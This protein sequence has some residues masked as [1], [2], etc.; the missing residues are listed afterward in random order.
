[1]PRFA[2]GSVCVRRRLLGVAPSFS[3]QIKNR[4]AS[5]LSSSSLLQP[6]TPAAVAQ[7]RVGTHALKIVEVEKHRRT[8]SGR[9][10]QIR[11]FAHRVWANRVA[12]VRSQ[13][14]AIRAFAGEHIEVV[15]PE[16]DHHFLQLPLAINSS[17]NSRSL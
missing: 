5:H 17:Q 9:F 12:I 16:I 6:P 10:Q 14:P 13:Q 3:H 2:F 11:E 15:G 7:L 8:F 4:I 1:M